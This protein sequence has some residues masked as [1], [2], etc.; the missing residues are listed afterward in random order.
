M[1]S[2][3]LSEDIRLQPGDLLFVPQNA[4]SKIKPFFPSSSVSAF[5]GQGPL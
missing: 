1:A 2:K 4:F 3:D 5:L